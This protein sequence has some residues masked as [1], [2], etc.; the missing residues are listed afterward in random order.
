LFV[1]FQSLQEKVSG[2]HMAVLMDGQADE[3][4]NAANVTELQEEY[5]R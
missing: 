4:N 3:K 1:L 2:V 5:L